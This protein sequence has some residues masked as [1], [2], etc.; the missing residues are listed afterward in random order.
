VFSDSN[1]SAHSVAVI[2]SFILTHFIFR[3]SCGSLFVLRT[4]SYDASHCQASSLELLA[5]HARARIS[6]TVFLE[7]AL[8]SGTAYAV[9]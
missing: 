1:V 6:E 4:A 5:F 8:D 2:D 9:C 7:R 3:L